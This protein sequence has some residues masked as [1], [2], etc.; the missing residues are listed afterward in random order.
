MVERF[1]LT[2]AVTAAII[3]N[4]VLL[5]RCRLAHRRHVMTMRFGRVHP[6][7]DSVV[8]AAR[9]RMGSS[10][11]LS[12][13]HGVSKNRCQS[14]MESTNCLYWER[15]RRQIQYISQWQ[16]R[17]GCQLRESVNGTVESIATALRQE[18]AA[19]WLDVIPLHYTTG[20]DEN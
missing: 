15:G 19:T 4:S 9:S 6:V 3:A 18:D 13:G 10:H 1:D 20:I 8:S 2:G 7:F 11:P 16:R 12:T 5:K 17:I 14:G